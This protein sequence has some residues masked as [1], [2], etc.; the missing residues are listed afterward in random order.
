MSTGELY[1]FVPSQTVSE[2][3]KKRRAGSKK[4]N[5]IEVMEVALDAQKGAKTSDRRELLAKKSAWRLWLERG[6]F[7]P[8]AGQSLRAT[9]WLKMLISAT[10]S[11]GHWKPKTLRAPVL[12]SFIV[13][14]LGL[15]A[16]LELLNKYSSSRDG[17]LVQ[18]PSINDLPLYGVLGYQYL[19][20]VISVCYSMLWSW[21]DLDVKRLEPWFRMSTQEGANAEDSLLLQYPFDF[22]AFVPIRAARRK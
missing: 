17:G 2:P 18:V 10:D 12:G 3:R 20:T 11:D 16:I 7:F 9:Y 13:I 5:G 4:L 8:S 15:I 21:V 19:P 22:L 1:G 14:S 6:S